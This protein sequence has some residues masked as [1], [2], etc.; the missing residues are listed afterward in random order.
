MKQIPSGE[1]LPRKRT[2][3]AY[4][5]SINTYAYNWQGPSPVSTFKYYGG[6]VWE[7]MSDF[8]HKSFKR[9]VEA[10]EIVMSPMVHIIDSYESSGSGYR[11]VTNADTSHW[12]EC[13]E[14]MTGTII[15]PPRR[16]DFLVSLSDASSLQTQVSTSVVSQRGRSNANTAENL[17]EWNKTMEL[18]RRP[19][20]SWMAKARKNRWVHTSLSGANGYLVYRYGISP[21]IRDMSAILQNL[22]TPTPSRHTTRSSES[23]SVSQQSTSETTLGLFGFNV[24]RSISETYTVRG[25]S[26]DEDTHPG[27]TQLRQLGLD[28]KSLITLPWELVPYSF[29]LDWFVNVGDVLGAVTDSLSLGHRNLGSCLVGQRVITDVTSYIGYQKTLQSTYT[30]L[31]SPCGTATNNVTIKQRDVGLSK[32]GFVVKSDFRFDRMTRIGDALALVV[33][34]LSKLHR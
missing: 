34:Q 18:L 21:L 31:R 28:G 29:V 24:Q 5:A 23:T 22:K 4:P 33:Q 30:V 17:A 27:I 1:T 19:L 12:E 16:P 14:N 7:F 3:G 20:A 2:R 8:V 15:G 10:K 26:I 25:M 32:I 6:S 9:R 11:L 13:N